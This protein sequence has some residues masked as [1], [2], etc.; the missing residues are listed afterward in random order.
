MTRL[1]V[2]SDSQEPWLATSAVDRVEGIDGV[3]AD[4]RLVVIEVGIVTNGRDAGS[5]RDEW[6]AVDRCEAVVAPLASGAPVVVLM[7]RG[8]SPRTTIILSMRGTR[9]ARQARLSRPTCR[10]KRVRRS[11]QLRVGCAETR[12]VL[13]LSG[14]RWRQSTPGDLHAQS[15]LRARPLPE[16]TEALP[17]RRAAL[18]WDSEADDEAQVKRSSQLGSAIVGDCLDHRGL[19]VRRRPSRGRSYRPAKSELPGRAVDTG[20]RG[21]RA[22]FGVEPGRKRRHALTPE[23]S[24]RTRRTRSRSRSTNVACFQVSQPS[25]C[26]Q[27]ST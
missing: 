20:K 12:H 26:V 9:R 21:K 2:H 17:H 22:G 5:M 7:L 13:I 4:L 3:R 1:G 16:H 18:R 25:T 14:R 11:K 6:R 23:P 24:H 19:R 10:S 27:G 15:W 8:D